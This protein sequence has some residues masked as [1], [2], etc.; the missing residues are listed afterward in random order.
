MGA[1]HPYLID[2]ETKIAKVTPWLRASSSR[3]ELLR[4]EVSSSTMRLHPLSPILSNPDFFLI[5]KGKYLQVQPQRFH[6]RVES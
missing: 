6:L 1:S 2:D 5:P 3:K 4:K